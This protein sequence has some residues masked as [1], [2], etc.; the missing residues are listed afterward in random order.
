[1]DDCKKRNLTVLLYVTLILILLIK[2][3]SNFETSLIATELKTLR[4]NNSE[5]FK[6]VEDTRL[7]DNILSGTGQM[8]NTIWIPDKGKPLLLESR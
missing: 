6:I 8:N 7:C 2:W 4:A 1:M 3:R 5:M